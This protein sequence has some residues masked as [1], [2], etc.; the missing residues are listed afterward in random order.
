LP[1][2]GDSLF[3]EATTKIGVD[4]AAL[5]PLN[6]LSHACIGDALALGKLGQPLHLEYAHLVSLL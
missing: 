1:G 5:G 3:D 4:D 6:R 2:S